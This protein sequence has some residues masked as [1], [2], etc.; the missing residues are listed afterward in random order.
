MNPKRHAHL[1]IECGRPAVYIHTGHSLTDGLI[2]G[3]TVCVSYDAEDVLA[4][5]T[6]MQGRLT[7]KLSSI[8]DI[9][10]WVDG[11]WKLEDLT[12]YWPGEDL[13]AD[14][15]REM[16]RKAKEAKEVKECR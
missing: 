14:D 16:V 2:I 10:V 8:A 15:I 13:T 12:P 5:H 3:D 4:V 1:C 9:E 11:R 6:R 7:G